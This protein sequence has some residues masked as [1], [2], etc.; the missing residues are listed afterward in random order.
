MRKLFVSALY[1]GA[2]VLFGCSR[3]P[4]RHVPALSSG[5]FTIKAATFLPRFKS[6]RRIHILLWTFFLSWNLFAEFESGFIR[7]CLLIISFLLLIIRILYFCTY[8]AK[9]VASSLGY[10]IKQMLCTISG[11]YYRNNTRESTSNKIIIMKE[12]VR[13][14][15]RNNEKNNPIK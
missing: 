11:S 6:P 14:R 9:P 7:V 15:R 3:N 5:F 10:F 4:S 12:F 2:T 13:R 1:F 8:F